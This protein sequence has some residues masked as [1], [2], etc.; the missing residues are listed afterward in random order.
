MKSRAPS[1][2]WSLPIRFKTTTTG[3]ATRRRARSTL[4]KN[5]KK[6][7]QVVTNEL[8]SAVGAPSGATA[9]RPH[10]TRGAFIPVAAVA[11]LQA[12]FDAKMDATKRALF[13]KKRGVR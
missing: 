4:R 7:S 9:R 2:A 11:A 13:N 12:R 6:I 5:G 1:F 10:G 8:I 3:T